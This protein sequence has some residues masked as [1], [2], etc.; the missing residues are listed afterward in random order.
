MDLSRLH[1]SIEL[2]LVMGIVK[3]DAMFMRVGDALREG[4]VARDCVLCEHVGGV[5]TSL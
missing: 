4:C 2:F 3:T 1:S 5:L